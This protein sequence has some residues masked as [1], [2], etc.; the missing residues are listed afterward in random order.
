MEIKSTAVSEP[1]PRSLFPFVSLSEFGGSGS[2][3]HT[4][5]VG[6]VIVLDS[7]VFY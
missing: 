5:H 6:E 2:E 4:A 7:V 3:F 1:V